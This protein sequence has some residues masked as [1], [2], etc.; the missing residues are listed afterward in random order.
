MATF[1]ASFKTNQHFAA[2]LSGSKTM[3]AKFG[4][5]QQIVTS[6]YEKLNNLPH[7]NDVKVIGRKTGADYKLQDK[8]DA[9]TV[10]EIE[11]I[12]YLD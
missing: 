1:K 7:I 8:M 12:L 10:Q 5:I 3:D 6:D 9:M 2:N 11:K 4:N